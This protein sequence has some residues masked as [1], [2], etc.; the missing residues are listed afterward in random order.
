MLSSG[1][2][3]TELHVILTHDLMTFKVLRGCHYHGDLVLFDLTPHCQYLIMINDDHLISDQLI[4]HVVR[5]HSKGNA[6]G[7]IMF[8]SQSGQGDRN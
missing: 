8:S 6:I 7:H 3:I 5:V 4:M 1:K 2:V